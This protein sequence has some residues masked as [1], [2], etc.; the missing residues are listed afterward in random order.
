VKRHPIKRIPVLIAVGAILLIGLMRWLQ[1]GFFE[2]LERMTYDMRARQALRSA[3]P[4]TTNLGFVFID[5]ASI[6]F[7]RT[8]R[9]LGW[10]A[11]VYWPRHVYGRV[12]EE[13]AAQ[14]A[15]AVALDVMFDGLRPFD[16]PVRM[17][18][19]SQMESDDF[20]ALQMRRAGN[21]ILAVSPD[22]TPPLL[23]R[24]NAFALGDIATHRDNPEGVLRRAQAFRLI[25]K[26][27]L[28]FRQLAAD[29]E[30]GVD[31]DRA[32]VEGVQVIL[33]RQRR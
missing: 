10:N 32:R 26:W 33:P 12:V 27:H 15:R 31:L 13:L 14:G 20:F 5:D 24:T 4:A 16:Y 25:R 3:P 28:A 2:S 1:V 19:D 9:S 7:V 8:N 29:P 30:L 11:Y 21:V 6:A 17:A 22:L 18:N 23:F